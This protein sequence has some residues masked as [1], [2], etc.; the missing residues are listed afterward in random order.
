MIFNGIEFPNQIIT[1]IKKGKLVVFAGAGVSMGKPTNL[2]DFQ[3]LAQDIAEG[4]GNVLKKTDSCEV[5]L[6]NLK[7]NKVPVNE[8]AAEMLSEACVEFN[9]LHEVVVDLFHSTDEIKIVTTNY[10][11]MFEK[12]FESKKISSSVFSSPALPLGND[13][14][15]LIHIHGTVDYSKYMV[16]TDEDFGKAYL[17]DGYVSRFLV[18]LFQNYVVLFIG[19]SYKDTIMRYLTRAMF[20]SN[21]GHMYVLT[22]DTKSDWPLYGITPIVYPKKKHQMIPD[23][24]RF[25]G[26][27]S[28]MELSD[29]RDKISAIAD[30][31]PIDPSLDNEIKFC[32]ENEELILVLSKCV[33]N[34]EW[35]AYFDANRQFDALFSE[36]SSLDVADETWANWLCDNFVKDESIIS[37]FY[38]HNNTINSHFAK[39]ILLVLLAHNEV[40][41]DLFEQ[42]ILIC[43]EFIEEAQIIF[44]LIEIACERKLVAT[45]LRLFMRLFYVRVSLKKKIWTLNN[46]DLE[47]KFILRGDYYD[48]ARAWH[49]ISSIVNEEDAYEILLFARAKIHEIYGLYKVANNHQSDCEPIDMKML[50]IEDSKDSYFKENTLRIISDMYE[51][52]A[53]LMDNR[54]SELLKELL[55]MDVYS[56]SVLLSKIALKVVRITDSVSSSEKMNIVCKYLHKCTIFNKEQVFLLASKVYENTTSSNRKLLLDSIEKIGEPD[57]DEKYEIYN[58]YVWLHRVDKTSKRINK[59][60]EF[61][62]KEY[63]FAPRNHPERD[64][65]FSMDVS[66]ESHNESIKYCINQLSFEEI[67]K[68][69]TNDDNPFERY[70]KDEFLVQLSSYISG[71]YDWLIVF[72][73]YLLENHN[74]NRDIWNS[75]FSGVDSSN[76]TIDEYINLLN[77]FGNELDSS[78]SKELCELFNTIIRK[79]EIKRKYKEYEDSFLVIFDS[80]WSKR[81]EKLSELGRVIDQAYN[82]K[83]GVLISSLVWMV[84]YSD[85]GII[86]DRYKR[87][88]EKSLQEKNSRKNLIV[89]VLLGHINFLYKRD[90]V[91]CDNVLVPYLTL[92][93]K[94]TLAAAWEG[95]T[96][97]SGG[98]PDEMKHAGSAMLLHA[99]KYLKWF[100]E[101]TKHAFIGMFLNYLIDDVKKPTMKLIPAFYRNNTIKEIEIFIRSIDSK[102]ENMDEMSKRKW[103]DGWLKHYI[104]NRKKNKPIPL[105]EIENYD[106][107]RLLI[108][109]DFCFEEAVSIIIQ[110]QVPKNVDSL[111]WFEIYDKHFAKKYPR[112]VLAIIHKITKEKPE[113]YR[114]DYYIPNV[115]NEME[116]LDE[117]ESKCLIDVKLMLNIQ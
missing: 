85:S 115:L 88:F 112:E 87:R 111:F 36:N 63:N 25:L 84:S 11:K 41:D 61:Y 45:A 49:G 55:L 69:V 101:D 28:K 70:K 86:S 26:D 24:L 9:K 38:K 89:C 92:K 5:F 7:A 79:E 47:Y 37:L 18:D 73:N 113:N 91:W 78:Y 75:L 97:I 98:I 40:P 39:Q 20:R 80:L 32:L 95:I 74:L 12:V 72:V 22:D 108:N 94:K 64:F 52:A 23:A 4:T 27:Y 43:E 14:Q 107:L 21:H 2:P 19:Y 102:L 100:S 6:G 58:W 17:K 31:P 105:S 42:Y 65:D 15:G 48:I 62:Q 59:K 34:K 60:L 106:L 3:Q 1:A 82:S 56:D 99:I 57:G 71:D 110:R 54:Q 30:H 50:Q 114:S 116:N 16:V 29:W 51:F 53:K 96:T 117:K 68:L 46:E 104:D 81:D 76:Y 35:I 93:N 8:I 109:L 10:D 67:I 44:M 33:K 103:W 83:C 77:I 66:N 90:K 13:V